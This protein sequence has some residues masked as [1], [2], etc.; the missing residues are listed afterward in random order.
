MHTRT[1]HLLIVIAVFIAEILVATAFSNI[2]FVRSYIGDFLVVI[3]LYH[4]VR[5]FFDIPPSTLAFFVFMF[6]CS[7]EVSQHFHLVDALGLPRG[8]LLSILIGTSFS[9]LDILAYALG[10]LASFLVALYLIPE[11]TSKE[12]QV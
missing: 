9:W 8:G 3:L 4:L 6:A 11:R 1:R 12:E 10:C 5:V 2:T 7:V